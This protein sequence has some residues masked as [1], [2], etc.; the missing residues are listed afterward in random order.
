MFPARRLGTDRP[1]RRSSYRHRMLPARLEHVQKTEGLATTTA[2]P[3][4]EIISFCS[5]I[6]EADSIFCFGN[7]GYDAFQTFWRPGSKAASTASL[8][9]AFIQH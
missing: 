4:A 1:S 3:I 2:Y 5:D 6:T 8:Y 9:V 7:S